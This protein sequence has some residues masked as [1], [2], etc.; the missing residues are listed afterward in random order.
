[1]RVLIAGASGFLGSRL[2]DSLVGTGH[3]VTALVRRAPG[4]GE[5]RWG[6]YSADLD[7]DLVESADVVVNLA[8]SP[9]LGN[10][11]SRKW[12]EELRSSRVTTTRVLADAIASSTRKPALL[13]GNGISYYGDHGAEPVPETADSRGGAFLTAVTK[14]WQAATEP[15]ADA[16]ARVCILRTAPVMDRAS[17]PLRQQRLLFKA[18]LGGKLGNGSQYQPMISLR[19]WVAAVAFLAEHDDVSGPVNLCCPRTPTNAEF[20]RELA[21]LVHRP[22]FFAVPAVVLRPAAGRMAPELLGSVRAVPQ[23]LEDAGF[24][25]AD[26]TVADV[27]TSALRRV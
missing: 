1:M 12:A 26:P 9:T 27:L 4:P 17:A 13:A 11:H 8:G 15:A 7:P 20:T 2:R 21:R 3:D 19:D 14:E 10:P 18:G 5:A 24:R 6:P 23:A 22:A 25:F 16:G